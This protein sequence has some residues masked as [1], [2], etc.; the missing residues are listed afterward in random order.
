MFHGADDPANES[1]VQYES[2]DEAR[3]RSSP[4]TDADSEDYDF[5]SEEDDTE[6]GVR[7]HEQR[8]IE[9]SDASLHEKKFQAE[10]DERW[11]RS[12]KQ[13]AMPSAV[14]NDSSP[15]VA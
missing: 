4:G 3:V 2:G 12:G 10:S 13:Q 9:L 11:S 7:E 15:V 14:G 6:E 8:E 5:S 1:S